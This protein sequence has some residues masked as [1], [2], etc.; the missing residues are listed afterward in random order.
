MQVQALQFEWAW[1][2]PE[3]SLAVREAIA[4]LKGTVKIAGFTGAKG[5]VMPKP[6][7]GECGILPA[8]MAYVHE[9]LSFTS[10]SRVIF[11][12]ELF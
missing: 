8:L 9:A 1:Q 10:S 12:M 7:P 5:K 4:A 11:M 6:H 2:H 3:K